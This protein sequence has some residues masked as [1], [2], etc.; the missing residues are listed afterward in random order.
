MIGADDALPLLGNSLARKMMV[1]SNTTI[2][3]RMAKLDDG[4]RCTV[5]GC[6]R[7]VMSA[8]KV[9]LSSIICKYHVQLRAKHG[10][11]WHGSYRVADVKP[12]LRCAIL[13]VANNKAD[14]LIAY[15]LL[16]VRGLLNSAGAVIPAKSLKRRSA[17]EK[18][19]A[20]FARLRERGI[21]PDRL[22]AIY[23]AVSVL[24]EDDAYADRG[25]RFRLVQLA[26]RIHPLASGTH[27]RDEYWTTGEGTS[28]GSFVEHSYPR[29]SGLVLIAM[30]KAIDELCRGW[31]RIG[32]GTSAIEEV[33]AAKL[34]R[35]G[36][37]PSRLP[38]YQARKRSA[39]KP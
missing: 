28:P 1:N 2:K 37:H 23:I 22:L 34:A 26:K 36:E 11:T 17:A 35:F 25:E 9:G 24:I 3:Q 13:W 30:G 27:Q 12:Y 31:V 8:A 38:N 39:N 32:R 6:G 20:A 21:A 7:L 18:A 29:S 33:R 5:F 19:R 15:P 16:G 10:S 14:S 4:G